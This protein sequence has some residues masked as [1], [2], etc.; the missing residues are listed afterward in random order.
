MIV[1]KFAQNKLN[2]IGLGE[3]IPWHCKKD[4]QEFKNKT[5]EHV[6][7]M[8]RKT[9]DSLGKKPLPNR[10]NFVVSLDED[11]VKKMNEKNTDDNLYFFVGLEQALDLSNEFYKTHTGY[12]AKTQFIIGGAMLIESALRQLQDRIDKIELSI[13]DDDTVGDVQVNQELLY[14]YKVPIQTIYY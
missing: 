5:T 9:F 6:I 1:I 2:Y 11:Y 12:R 10:A 13:I 3:T 7:I 14:A 4:L 8:G